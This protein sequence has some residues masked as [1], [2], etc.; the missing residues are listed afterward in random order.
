MFLVYVWISKIPSIHSFLCC[1]QQILVELL[2][3]SEISQY[4]V[5]LST[6]EQ[7]PLKGYV[8]HKQSLV[9]SQVTSTALKFIEFLN[10]NILVA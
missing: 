2:I 4:I 5:I 7:H 3:W 1:G 8:I 9:S 10:K 6:D